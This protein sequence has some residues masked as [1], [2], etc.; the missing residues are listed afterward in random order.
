MHHILP[1]LRCPT[2]LL[3]TIEEEIAALIIDNGSDMCKVAFLG[4][5]PPSHVPSIFGCPWHGMM[6]SMGQKDSYVG[7]KAQSKCGT[8]TSKYPIE[9][10]IVTN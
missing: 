4:T 8:L 10:G 2:P 1:L 3:V 6:V 9:H 7:N 5:M